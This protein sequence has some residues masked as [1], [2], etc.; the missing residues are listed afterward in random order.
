M[1]LP[2]KL[3]LGA[4]GLG[5]IGAGAYLLFSDSGSNLLAASGGL[6]A[7]DPGETIA[8]T[9]YVDGVPTPLDLVS[10][11]HGNHYLV[12]DAAA[13]FLRMEAAANSDGVTFSINSSFRTM[14]Q[15]LS[16]LSKLGRYKEGGL[17]AEA[18]KSP[19][20]RGIALDINVGSSGRGTPGTNKAWKWLAEER[21]AARYGFVN[22]YLV[23]PGGEAW[24]FSHEPRY[25]GRF[26]GFGE[27]V[28][29]AP[30]PRYRIG[31]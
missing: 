25:A 5:S 20:Q 26:A 30:S 8:A 29:F 13:A 14:E 23:N 18:G 7:F 31:L 21:N 10:I 1:D 6:P 28:A 2:T 24:H 17:A 19:H 3:L 15:Q 16:L 11:G 12:R 27:F 22:D 4:L 9:G